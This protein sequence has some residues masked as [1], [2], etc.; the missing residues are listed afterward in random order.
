MHCTAITHSNVVIFVTSQKRVPRK[1]NTSRASY[2]VRCRWFAW[3]VSEP[4]FYPLSNLAPTT[5]KQVLNL[6]RAA[7][8]VTVL[9]LRVSHST[10]PTTSAAV[11]RREQLRQPQ[12][13]GYDTGRARASEQRGASP[14]YATTPA[15]KMVSAE[16]IGSIFIK[17]FKV[18]SDIDNLMD[19]DLTKFRQQLN[20][21]SCL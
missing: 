7:I 2:R 17:V 15:D 19:A 3:L 20:S 11:R 10:G 5:D 16:T 8:S 14:R 6:C 1:T 13:R 21:T 9:W 4:I 18:V 12:N